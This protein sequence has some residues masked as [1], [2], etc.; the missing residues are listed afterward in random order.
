MIYKI[1]L[2]LILINLP[3]NASTKLSF[4]GLDDE[5]YYL[6]IKIENARQTYSRVLNIHPYKKVMR[7]VRDILQP[8]ETLKFFHTGMLTISAIL[9]QGTI[10]IASK[11]I[12]RSID[13]DCSK[14]VKK[15][16][17]SLSPTVIDL[18]LTIYPLITDTPM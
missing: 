5:N 3:L 17:V 18:S 15:I 2:T 7:D 10:S 16:K 14:N 8:D 13:E 9:R 12:T 1:I 6:S 11:S 4:N